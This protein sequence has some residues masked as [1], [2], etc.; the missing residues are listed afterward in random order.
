MGGLIDC[1]PMPHIMTMQFQLKS[2]S[3]LL[4]RVVCQRAAEI[5]NIVD[6]LTLISILG[7]PCTSR[8]VIPATIVQSS[9]STR[10]ILSQLA[11]LCTVVY[12]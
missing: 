6:G 3:F 10:A 9:N 1:N 12:Q 5:Y 8:P 4:F 2:C 11:V 7:D